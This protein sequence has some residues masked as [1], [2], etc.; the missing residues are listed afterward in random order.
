M[1]DIVGKLWIEIAKRIVG[2]GPQVDNGVEALEIARSLQQ[3]MWAG[4]QLRKGGGR[5]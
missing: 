5:S 3:R 1:V 2:K 4:I